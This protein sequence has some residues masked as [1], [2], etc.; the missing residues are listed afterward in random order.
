MS[1][2]ALLWCLPDRTPEISGTICVIP[3]GE[4]ARYHWVT[5]RTGLMTMRHLLLVLG[6]A[7]AGGGDPNIGQITAACSRR[8]PCDHAIIGV[9]QMTCDVAGRDARLIA[10]ASANTL[11]TVV[12]VYGSDYSDEWPRSPAR[13]PAWHD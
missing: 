10:R 13:R 12:M 4:T 5:T 9:S 3:V 2:E 1:A 8:A 6:S 11:S 7:D